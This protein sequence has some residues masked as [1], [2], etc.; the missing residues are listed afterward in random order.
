MSEKF[1]QEAKKIMDE[2]FGHDTLP[3]PGMERWNRQ[4][5]RRRPPTV[6]KAANICISRHRKPDTITH[7]TAPTTKNWTEA[8]LTISTYPLRKPEKKSLPSMSYRLGQWNP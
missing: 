2:R 7:C 3:L 5:P 8:S 6:W 1:P 4:K